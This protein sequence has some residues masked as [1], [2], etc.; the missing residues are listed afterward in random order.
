MYKGEIL[1][2]F[3]LRWGKGKFIL[4]IS[5]QYCTMGLSTKNKK[6]K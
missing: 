3:F 5:I 1:K 4:T 6:K 2:P